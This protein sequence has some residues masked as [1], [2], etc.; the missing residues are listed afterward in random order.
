MIDTDKDF[1]ITIS[2]LHEDLE[3]ATQ[4][5]D[6]LAESL[7]V[8]IYT[9]KQ[10]ELAGTDGLE[11]FRGVFRHRSHLVVIL[12]RG[13]WGTTPWTRVEMEA[14]TDRFLA[15][16][17]A[18]LFV[19]MMEPCTPP[20]WIPEKLIRFSLADFGLEQAVG[21]IKARALE[22]GSELHRPTTAFIAERAQ[23]RAQFAASRE[24]LFRTYE[25]VQQ[26]E[27]EAE[28]VITGIKERTSEAIEAAPALGIEFGSNQLSAVIR[29]RSVSVGCGYRNNIVNV[30]EKAR[31]L[32]TE[33]RGYVILPGESAYYH[34]QPKELAV[35]EF[36][37]ELT[38]EQ[39][40]CWRP[41]NGVTYTSSEVATLFVERFFDL[42]E[43][44]SAGK[45]PQLDF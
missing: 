28:R 17:P 34:I 3:T 18:F 10:E 37:P 9:Q 43:R 39:G 23:R 12:L 36:K 29:M 32:I 13:R 20:R 22:Q 19:V 42:V 26:A 33:F 1:D 38:E 8:F 2:F 31:L 35:L 25:G 5:R 24:K 7:E 21:A 14:I 4:L 45:L 30:L 27:A 40:W 15:E 41:K 6:A 16:G 44:Q 11:S